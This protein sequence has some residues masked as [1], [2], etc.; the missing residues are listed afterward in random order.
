MRYKRDA[1][2]NASEE[3]VL[4]IGDTVKI[5]K[6]FRRKKLCELTGKYNKYYRIQSM[7]NINI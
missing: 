6:M 7:V 5:K 2:S 1:K 4:E 3:D